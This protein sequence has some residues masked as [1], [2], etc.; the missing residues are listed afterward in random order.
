[1]SSHDSKT[2]SD[3]MNSDYKD[4]AMYVIEQRAIPSVIDGFKP[5]QRKIAHISNKIWKT[6]KEREIK[7]FQLT[8]RVSDQAYYHHGDA[9]LNSAIINMAQKFKN[10]LPLLDEIGQFGTLRSPVASAPRY[11]E[12]KLSDNF[13]AVYKD[14]ELLT[15][16]YDEGVEIEPSYFLPIIPT[17][18]LN[19]GQ[20]IAVG[21]ST[22]IL[23]RNVDEVINAVMKCI[24]GKKVKDI[25]PK[26]NGFKG[27]YE[28]D[29]E[30]HK[31]WY[32]KG[33]YE[34]LNTTTVEVTELPPNM[35]FEKYESHLDSLISKKEIVSYEDNSSDNVHYIIKMKREKLTKATPNKIVKLLKLEDTETEIYTTLDEHGKLKIF[36]TSGEIVEYFT[37]FRLGYYQKRKDYLIDKIDR[38]LK[39]LSNKAKF[40][41]AII[42]G[43]LK[44][45]N[46]P[47]A[48][49]IKGIEKLEID[50]IDDSYDYLLRMSI[51]NLTKEMY[52]KL[53]NDLKT[54]KE[55]LK[56]VKSRDIKEW[57]KEDLKQLKKDLK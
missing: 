12:T 16:K 13:K 22:N 35:T 47:K 27:Q 43:D 19:G 39:I 26:L 14:F 50:K 25:A 28:Q 41:K 51:Y 55:E 57:Y 4:F 37:N 48:D 24:D 56:V 45:N 29:E 9:S 23:N 17:V 42:D 31:K 32:I 38:E 6:G 49:I 3:Y 52:D 20:G 11:I 53:K 34:V 1:M 5:V 21:F 54:K 44:V 10:N 36:E 18:L 33:C 30:N 40:V 8:G 2:I 7:V 46:V 15:P